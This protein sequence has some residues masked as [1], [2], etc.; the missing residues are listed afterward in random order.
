MV[1]A[2]I[3]V[4]AALAC[5]AVVPPAFAQDPGATPTDETE[6]K[7]RGIGNVT[8]ESSGLNDDSDLLDPDL[9]GGDFAEVAPVAN[10]PTGTDKIR[11]DAAVTQL[12]AAG[13]R[14]GGELVALKNL[15][16]ENPKLATDEIG[17]R[18]VEAD[19][20][21]G[22]LQA[23]VDQLSSVLDS[24]ERYDIRRHGGYGKPITMQTE[25]SRVRLGNDTGAKAAARGEPQFVWWQKMALNLAEGL[26]ARL[27]PLAEKRVNALKADGDALS[28]G[29]AVNV[30]PYV[31]Q[32]IRDEVGNSQ[33]GQL[34]KADRRLDDL[35]IPGRSATV[36]Q[37]PS[38]A[39]PAPGFGDGD[40]S[41]PRRSGIAASGLLK[42]NTPLLATRGAIQA[43]LLPRE[44]DPITGRERVVIDLPG[45]LGSQ[46]GQ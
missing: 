14:L 40:A 10:E 12:G 35:L 39:D 19:L 42:V 18:E 46:S 38:S 45:G 3:L 2:R 9:D 37:K 36:A 25:R 34:G 30:R 17:K 31:D 5:L 1:M 24:T 20:Q 6:G 27:K 29:V 26:D 8:L 23:R 7:D 16:L 44:R 41:E 13:D 33:L 43:Y 15:L 22:N 32:V 4:V 28:L 21:L 11:L